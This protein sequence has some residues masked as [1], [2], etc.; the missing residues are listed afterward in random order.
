M[1]WDSIWIMSRYGLLLWMFVLCTLFPLLEKLKL[2]ML[3]SM[4]IT[5]DTCTKFGIKSK[6]DTWFASKFSG[7]DK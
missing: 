1:V 3:K 2:A 6:T 7:P 4:P 5:G